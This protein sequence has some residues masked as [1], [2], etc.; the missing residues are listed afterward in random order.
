MVALGWGAVSYERGTP[1]RRGT[2]ADRE[3]LRPEGP[4]KGPVRWTRAAAA[5]L[6]IPNTLERSRTY[7]TQSVHEAVL[8]KAITAQILQR[9]L[10]ISD[11]KGKVDGF[12]WILTFEK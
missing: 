1:V 8:Q 2:R 12:V 7:L 10:Y 6:S 11:N 4:A 5:H 9:T 3:R